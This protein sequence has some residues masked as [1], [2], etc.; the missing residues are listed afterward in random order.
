VKKLYFL[1]IFSVLFYSCTTISLREGLNVNESED[2]LTIGRDA[3][4]TNIAPLNTK[5]NPPFKLIWDYNA[6]SGFGRNAFAVSDGVLFAGCLNGNVLAVNLK[7]GSGIGKAHTKSK[8]CFSNPLI[9]KDCIIMTFSDGTMNYITSYDFR[10]GVFNWKYS[11]DRI[12]SSPLKKSDF[13]YYATLPGRILKVNIST[14]FQEVIYKNEDSYFTSPTL[15]GDLLLEGDIKGNM[16]ALNCETGKLEWSF[17]TGDGIYSDVSVYN[18]KVFFGSDDKYFYCL[19]SAGSLLWKK[20]LDTKF[21]SSSA[22]YEDNVIISGINGK[23]YSIGTSSG[24]INWE[25]TSGGAIFAS[26]VLNNGKIFIGSFDMYFYC[27]D[28]KSGSVLWKYYLDDR[29]RTTAVIWKNLIL[30]ANDDKHI[31]CF[32]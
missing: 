12:M 28:A 18:N 6:E 25:F 2:W 20:Y 31:Y 15:C 30:V 22:F 4:K 26:P 9:L 13:I 27:L 11:S 32:K 3:G 7:N 19:D 24:E 29:I 23:V 16:T 5:L 10:N 14:G 21:L 8:A 17:K 1:L